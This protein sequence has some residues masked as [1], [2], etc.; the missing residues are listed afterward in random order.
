MEADDESS[1]Q[2]R[3][4]DV[5]P[6]N[7]RARELISVIVPVYN[8]EG[9][10][11]QLIRRVTDIA[12]SATV[13]CEII[14]VDNA[15]TD[16][17]RETLVLLSREDDRIKYIR[18]S[19][20]F[21]PTVDTSLMAGMWAARGDAV[22]ILYG[23]LQDPP[24]VVLEFIEQWR[25]G[26]DVVYGVQT[27]RLGEPL[28]RRTSAKV[29]YKLLE[30]ISDSPVPADA[31]DFRLLSR[32]VVDGVLAMPERARFTRGLSTW[33]GYPHIGVPYA[34]VRRESG[35]SK[36]SPFAITR[37]ALTGI[38]G[39]SLKPLRILTA[40]GV[41]ISLLCMLLVVVLVVMWI[42]GSPLPGL[43][44]VLVLV[45]LSTGLNLGG[46][47]L[48]GE[49]LGRMQLEIKH[50]PHFVIAETSNLPDVPLGPTSLDALPTKK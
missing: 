17:T 34:R 43:T 10:L 9:S 2:T 27:A 39:F 32:R 8:E 20:N 7:E 41:A 28:W 1:V 14:F 30:T 26:Y 33:I 4:I 25:A 5:N 50:R 46:L 37:T 47:G 6:I 44:S 16:A 31:G 3:V 13:D 18:M 48:I 40:A 36:A 23:D 29:F 22:V 35:K 42:F 49:Y 21:G 15:S 19:R 11:G 12:D 24:E 38:T 45:L